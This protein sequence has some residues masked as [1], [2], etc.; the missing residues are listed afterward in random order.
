MA[1][2]TVWGIVLIVLGVLLAI[3]GFSQINESQAL[4]QVMGEMVRGLGGASSQMFKDAVYSAQIGGA[5]KI[6]LGIILALWGSLLVK[7]AEQKKTESR[8]NYQ[9]SMSTPEHDD[10]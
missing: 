8:F 3:G 9:D 1:V 10:Y 6:V 5:I 7:D 2:K 4:D